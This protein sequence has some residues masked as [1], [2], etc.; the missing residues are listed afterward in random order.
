[1]GKKAPSYTVALRVAI[2]MNIT[3]TLSE[4]FVLLIPHVKIKQSRY[5]PGVAQ[6]V[7]GS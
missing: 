6:R 5:R 7:P 3:S 1:M 4:K 2:F